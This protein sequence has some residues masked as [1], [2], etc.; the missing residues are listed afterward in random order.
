VPFGALVAGEIGILG[1]GVEVA[2]LEV[3][4]DVDVAG[5]KRQALGRAFLHEAID[6]AGELGLVAVV[7][8]VALEHDHFVGAPFA[9]LEGAGAGIAG[10]QPF[11]AEI[12]VVLVVGRWRDRLDVV[13]N[14]LLVDDGSDRC[15]Q[16]V[17]HEARRIGLVDGEGE[18]ACV[19]CLGLFGDIVARDAELGD[20]EGRALVELDGALE[21]PGDVFG[22]DRVAGGELHPGLQL[23]RIGQAVIGNGPA[24]GEIA[25][26]LRRVGHVEAHEKAIGVGW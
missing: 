10:L 7:I 4:G 26:D 12:V 8:V 18:G 9:Q 22:G 2:G 5:L 6:D 17:Q 25:L 1:D 11:I 13:E 20:D 16:A 19:G 21:R 14:Q 3:A 15:R 24:V 23:E